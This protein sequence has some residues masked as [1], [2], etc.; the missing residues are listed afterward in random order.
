MFAICAQGFIAMTFF[1]DAKAAHRK[2]YIKRFTLSDGILML[3]LLPLIPL[4]MYTKAI[5][6]F[7]IEPVKDSFFTDFFLEYFGESHLLAPLLGLLLLIYLFRVLIKRYDSTKQLTEQPLTMSFVVML[8]WVFITC[9]IPYLRSVLVVPMMISRYTIIV[10]PAYVV[11]IAM[12]MELVNN[13]V[14]RVMI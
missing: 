10:L 5:K 2:I 7:W 11:V 9:F 12:G 13:T 6:V 8:L 3:G 14:A 4:L 1:I